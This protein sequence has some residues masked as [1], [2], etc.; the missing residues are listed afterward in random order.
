MV[1]T[2]VSRYSKE[3]FP[4]ESGIP[5]GAYFLKGLEVD[6]LCQVLRI[7]GISRETQTYTENRFLIS[8]Q[9]I[10]IFNFIFG[11]LSSCH[12]TPVETEF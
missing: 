7:Q 9:F 10:K 11:S 8:H 4:H 3:P 6:I 12:S 1:K 2:G 5:Q